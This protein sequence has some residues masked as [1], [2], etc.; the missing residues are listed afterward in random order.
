[1]KM[2]FIALI[3][4]GALIIISCKTGT[5]QK[6]RDMVLTGQIV[7][8]LKAVLFSD[9]GYKDQHRI[10]D[11]YELW[12]F[13]DS[14]A[15]GLGRTLLE[16][17]HSKLSEKTEEFLQS[18]RL[19]EKAKEDSLD[20]FNFHFIGFAKEASERPINLPYFAETV[21]NHPKFFGVRITPLNMEPIIIVE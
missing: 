18:Q 6:E 14:I 20:Y 10:L 16:S 5:I 13:S 4:L 7:K 11:T 9:E 3:V 12:D 2:N 15:Y 17:K 21:L 1:M 19:L 8:D